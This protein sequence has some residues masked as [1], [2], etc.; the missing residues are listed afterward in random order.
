MLEAQKENKRV[1][2]LLQ[3]TQLSC[4]LV[5]SLKLLRTEI[6]A[7]VCDV[8][9]VGRTL[10]PEW[11]ILHFWFL[12]KLKLRHLY[13][14]AESHKVLSF[15]Q[16][17]FNDAKHT[18]LSRLTTSI[19]VETDDLILFHRK[20]KSSMSKKLTRIREAQFYTCNCTCSRL[21]FSV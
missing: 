1:I 14:R 20:L 21:G 15:W 7:T 9:L 4:V 11:P 19:S 16:H 2:F 18:R 8:F 3:R 13:Y 6:I 12:N 5:R 10:L 17:A